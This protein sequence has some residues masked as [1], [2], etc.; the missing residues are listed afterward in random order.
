MMS[1]V[2]DTENMPLA[3][4]VFVALLWYTIKDLEHVAV[5]AVEVGELRVLAGNCIAF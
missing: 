5:S 3:K 1:V 4:A 2:C